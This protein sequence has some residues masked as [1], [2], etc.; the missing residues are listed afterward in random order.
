VERIE[1]KGSSKTRRR[2][3][4]D[5]PRF[6]LSRSCGAENKLGVVGNERGSMK[7]VA[8]EEALHPYYKLVRWYLLMQY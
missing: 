6:T 5:K 7:R 3:V 8:R 4:P 1:T 2:G